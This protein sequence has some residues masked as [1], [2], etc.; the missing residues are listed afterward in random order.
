MRNDRQIATIGKGAVFIRLPKTPHRNWNGFLA[1][2]S[3]R[4]AATMLST[5]A[6][7]CT[8]NNPMPNTPT[9]KTAI[10]LLDKYMK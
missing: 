3:L 2:D 9:G 5:S 6:S 10:D 8:L 1:D 7:G 4:E